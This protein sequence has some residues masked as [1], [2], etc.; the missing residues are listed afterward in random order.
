MQICGSVKSPAQLCVEHGPAW[1]DSLFPSSGPD[2]ASQQSVY[3]EQAGAATGKL[4]TVCLG[5]SRET[6]RS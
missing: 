5:F 2:A 1:E 4:E 3:W 6:G